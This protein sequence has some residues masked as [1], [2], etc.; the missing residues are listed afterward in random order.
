ME[1]G[2]G[3]EGGDEATLRRSSDRT[4]SDEMRSLVGV[5]DQGSRE[6]E[7]SRRVTRVWD[8]CQRQRIENV[9]RWAPRTSVSDAD[10]WTM[11][12]PS[13]TGQATR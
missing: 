13:G 6:R 1:M 3:E 8:L 4:S 5:A 10:G 7:I 2:R 12:Q 11:K 9:M